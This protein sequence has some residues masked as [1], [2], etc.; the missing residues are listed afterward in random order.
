MRTLVCTMD[1]CPAL[2]QHPSSKPPSSRAPNRRRLAWSKDSARNGNP[3]NVPQLAAWRPAGRTNPACGRGPEAAQDQESFA[4]GDDFI[5]A[6]GG[7]IGYVVSI[8]EADAI[9]AWACRGQSTKD[10]TKLTHIAHEG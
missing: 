3:S 2:A 1:S 5:C 6:H 9:I 4:I 8:K 10:V 7:L